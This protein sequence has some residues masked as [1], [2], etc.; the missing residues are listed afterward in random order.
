MTDRLLKFFV[1]HKPGS[2]EHFSYFMCWNEPFARRTLDSAQSSLSLSL[3]LAI[4]VPP[5]RRA[6]IARATS[7]PAMCGVCVRHQTAA[8]LE[9]ACAE[10]RRRSARACMRERKHIRNFARVHAEAI[11]FSVSVALLRFHRQISLL[12]L[13]NSWAKGSCEKNLLLLFFLCH[14]IAKNHFLN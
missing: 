10:C 4:F 6:I 7:T 8:S 13:E 2:C 5:D 14:L 9:S 1:S 12:N 11:N 3:S